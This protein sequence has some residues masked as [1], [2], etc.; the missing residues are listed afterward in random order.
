MIA[1]GVIALLMAVF[2]PALARTRS[3]AWAAIGL[4]NLRQIASISAQYASEHDHY[5]PALGQPWVRLPFWA[6]VVQE[7]AQDS[8]ADATYAGPGILRDPLCAAHYGRDMERCYAANATG[9]AG[10][11]GDLDNFDAGEV[12][13]HL[14]RIRQPSAMPWYLTS[15]VTTVTTNGPPPTRTS[16]ALDL[17]QAG[18]LENRLGRF[19]GGGRFLFS[20]FD[21]SAAMASEIPESWEET[22]P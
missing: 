18:H 19:A 2:L 10:L 14:D 12:F 1:V 7:R 5:S 17:R 6:L 9:R 16:G 3:A 4:S 22:L 13:I 21:G 8:D 11:D 20:A 15:A